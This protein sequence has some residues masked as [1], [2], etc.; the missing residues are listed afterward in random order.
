[1]DMK[2]RSYLS[3]LFYVLHDVYLYKKSAILLL[4]LGVLTTLGE[5]VLGTLTSYFVVLAL[6]NQEEPG[7]YLVLIAI[8]ASATFACT[9]LK[10]WG[11]DSYNW[12][13][14]FA[15][16]TVCWQRITRKTITTDYMNVEPREARKVIEK[17]LARA[18][19]Q[20]DR[21]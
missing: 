14:T 21:P 6:T 11:L 17:G 9:A 2:K 4:G 13:S 19:Q 12:D 5:A 7:H 20:L 10:I 16:C 8:L 18:R 1:M 3:N 15:R